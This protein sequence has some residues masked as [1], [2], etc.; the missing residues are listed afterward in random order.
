MPEDTIIKNKWIIEDADIFLVIPPPFFIKMPHIGVAYLASFLKQKGFKVSVYDL[1]LKL[2]NSGKEELKRFWGIGCTNSFFCTEIAD[3]IFQNFRDE[4]NKFIEEFLASKIKV[5][6]FSVNIISIFLANR[7]AKIIK[8]KDPERLIIFGGTGTFFKHPRDLIKPGF[9]DVYVI[10]EGESTLFNILDTYSNRKKIPNVPGILLAKDLGRY[11]PQASPNIQNL[12]ELPF[13]NFFEFDLEEYNQGNDYKPIPLLL[14]RGCIKRCTYCVDYV[15]W[16]KYRFRS[17]LNIMEEI[18]YHV[19]N[20]NAKAFEM[21]DLT[22]NGNLKQ[23]SQLCDLIIDSGL[24]FD[25]VSYAIIRQDMDLTLLSKMKKAGCHTLIYGVENGS[26]RILEMMGKDYTVKEAA[27]VIRLTRKA[28]ICTNINIIVGFPGENTEDFVQTVEFIRENKDYI[29]EVTNVSA[30]TLFPQ[31]ELGRNK[32]R[33]GISWQE[34]ID[35]MLFTD[36]NGLDLAGR[37]DRVARLAGIINNLD[38][39]K[40]IINKPALNPEVKALL[41]N[42]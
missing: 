36:S 18:R 23:L 1:S 21:N 9:A 2:H 17:P 10:G 38:L 41:N 8:E 25:W 28:G 29:D 3:T 4:I 11:Q 35:P 19:Q 22:C 27:Q 7:I 20:N 6:G 31:A 42:E 34:G 14:S 33:Y 16:P 12:D 15:M 5:I 26:D 13:P 24:K 30:C 40:S 32:K 39:S 37:N